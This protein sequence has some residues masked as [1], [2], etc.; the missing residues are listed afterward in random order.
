MKLVGLLLLCSLGLSAQDAPRPSAAC[1]SAQ[2]RAFDFWIG[3]W[4]VIGP[5]GNAAGRNV[6]SR[7]NG[8]C[9]ILES[10]VGS[11]AYVGQSINAYDA[12]RD[13]WQQT[14]SDIS[15]LVLRLE[16]SSPQP[17]VM[18]LEGSRLDAQRREVLDRITWTAHTD[19]SVRQHWE[20]STDKGATWTTTFD[21]RYVRVTTG[22]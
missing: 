11:G 13:R 15:G 22:R 8:G 10:Y 4:D 5:T 19:G 20:S 7:A 17:G 12:P 14:W 18:A 6:I 9:T 3:T 1:Q 21:G 16:G 2:H